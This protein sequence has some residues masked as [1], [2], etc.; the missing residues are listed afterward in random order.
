MPARGKPITDSDSVRDIVSK[1]GSKYGDV[2]KHC[3][4]SDI[5]VEVPL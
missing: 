2:K 5:A 3:P 4:K 1:Y